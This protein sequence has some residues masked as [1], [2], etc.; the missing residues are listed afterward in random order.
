MRF[1]PC[2]IESFP[3]FIYWQQQK[4]CIVGDAKI[5]SRRQSSF[6]VVW[7]IF[8]FEQSE[9]FHNTLDG[10]PV[11]LFQNQFFAYKY[12]HRFLSVQEYYVEQFVDICQRDDFYSLQDILFYF[13]EFLFVSLR[14]N[15]SL[16]SKSLCGI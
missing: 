3:C 8:F 5:G 1:Y 12:A 9:N 13:G 15:C 14:Y 16:Q 11:L 10:C 6:W 7:K 4:V 2:S